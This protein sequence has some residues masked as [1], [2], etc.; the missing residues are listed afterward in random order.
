[1]RTPIINCSAGAEFTLKIQLRQK[2]CAHQLRCRSWIY[3][4]HLPHQGCVFV[5]SNHLGWLPGRVRKSK[6][7]GG[8]SQGSAIEYF[9]IHMILSHIHNS[10]TLRSGSPPPEPPRVAAG[11]LLGGAIPVRRSAIG[12]T[13]PIDLT[14]TAG[15]VQRT[16]SSYCR[17]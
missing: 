14:R 12:P 1:M 4:Q 13:P 8:C 6:H 11:W 9:P 3:S 17:V 5:H 2:A 15:R 16:P 10:M 7:P